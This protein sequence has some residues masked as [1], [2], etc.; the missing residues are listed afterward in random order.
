MMGAAVDQIDWIAACAHRLHRQWRSVTIEDVEAIAASLW[1]DPVFK[2]MTP[3]K[4]AEQ[5][6]EPVLPGG[7]KQAPF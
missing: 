4:A 6:L 1:R 7:E 5:W 2:T 3:V